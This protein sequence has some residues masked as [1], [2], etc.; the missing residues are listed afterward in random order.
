MPHRGVARY[1]FRRP[2]PGKVTGKLSVPIVL[3]LADL[4]RRPS[5]GDT[6]QRVGDRSF[7]III[8]LAEL[9]T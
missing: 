6:D 5:L 1:E 2:T 9:F 7:R 8:E 4:I 3:K